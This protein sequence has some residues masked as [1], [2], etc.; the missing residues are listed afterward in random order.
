MSGSDP[1]RFDINTKRSRLIVQ[2]FVEGLL[3]SFGHNPKFS[4]GEINGEVQTVSDQPQTAVIRIQFRP[5]SLKLLDDVSEKDRKEI[6]ETMKNQVLETSRFPEIM[7]ESTGVSGE[8]I[9]QGRYQVNITGNLSLHGTT[10]P[11]K[12][13]AQVTANDGQLRAEG[14]FRL[15]Q[16]DYGI[17]LFKAAGGTLKVKDEVKVEFD[18]V[19]KR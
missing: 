1:I 7:L 2:A 8:M 11:E 15:R 12:L 9:F 16:T 5:D 18:V 4:V 3:S 14:D 17:K 10:R 6:E 19:A 13:Q